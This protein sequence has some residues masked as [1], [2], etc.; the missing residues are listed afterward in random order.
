MFKAVRFFFFPSV[1]EILYFV[2]SFLHFFHPAS[3]ISST[4]YFFYKHGILK[5]EAK[6]LY[7]GDKYQEHCQI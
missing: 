6:I 4:T 3:R 5:Y 7:G 2:K 1:Y